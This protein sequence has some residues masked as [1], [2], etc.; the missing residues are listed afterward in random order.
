M[1]L[2]W[3]SEEV[4]VLTNG[5]SNHDWIATGVSIDSRTLRSGALF[6]PLVGPKFDGH[7]YIE[8]AFKSGAVASISSQEVIGKLVRAPLI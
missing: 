7:D 2:S 6:I 5:Q 3:T 4:K 1:E 8:Y